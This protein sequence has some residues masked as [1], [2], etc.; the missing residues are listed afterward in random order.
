MLDAE[1]SCPFVPDTGIDR[2]GVGFGSLPDGIGDACQ[3][4][5]VSG[6]GFVTGT[7]ALMIRR[8]LLVPPSATLVSADL[9]DVGGGAGCTTGD[10]LIIRRALLVP[11]SATVLQRCGPALP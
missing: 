8:A 2:G 1:D 5:D 6:D 9:C 10:A 3:C 4:G 7:D 11:P